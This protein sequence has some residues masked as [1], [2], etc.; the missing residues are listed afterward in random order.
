MLPSLPELGVKLQE[1]VDRISNV[2]VELKT[3]LFQPKKVALHQ[4]NLH[5]DPLRKDHLQT[6]QQTLM[7]S[8]SSW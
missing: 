1:Q 8:Q 4:S 7:F 5:K 2:L 6:A 3:I